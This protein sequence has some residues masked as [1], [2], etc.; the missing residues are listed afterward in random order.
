MERFN[1]SNLNKSSLMVSRNQRGWDEK[2]QFLL[3]YFSA[4]CAV[5]ESTG[6]TPS[7]I[8]FGSE[9]GLPS[10]LRSSQGCAFIS[11]G[12]HVHSPDMVRRRLQLCTGSD[13]YGDGEDKKIQCES[14]EI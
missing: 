10:P 6:Y 7:K 11:I 14:N 1:W 8:L 12:V 13:P 9:L 2:L 4:Y 5:H 3:A